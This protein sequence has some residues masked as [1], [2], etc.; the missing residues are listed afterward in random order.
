MPSAGEAQKVSG[1]DLRGKVVWTR[2]LP[3]EAWSLVK[4]G[5]FAIIA[6]ADG[7]VRAL[8]RAGTARFEGDATGSSSDQFAIDEAGKPLRVT[9]RNVHLICA[10]FDGRVRWRA[11]SDEPFGPFVAGD[12]GVGVL[13]GRSLAWFKASEAA[14]GT[15]QE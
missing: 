1:H 12:A 7:R 3:W 6:S 5:P 11:V 8:D 4:A 13:L 10:A 2:Q 14:T 15:P 9:R